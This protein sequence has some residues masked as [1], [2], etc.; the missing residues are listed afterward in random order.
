MFTCFGWQVTL[1]DPTWP[2]T[3]RSSEI[4]CLGELYRLTFYLSHLYIISF[5]V[6]QTNMAAVVEKAD[7]TVPLITP[8]VV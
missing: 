3:S 1:C 5:V 2:L 6:N 7:R 4:T 8:T